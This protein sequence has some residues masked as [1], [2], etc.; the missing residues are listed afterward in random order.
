MTDKNSGPNRATAPSARTSG[1]PPRRWLW[2]LTLGLSLACFAVQLLFGTSEIDPHG[3]LY[4]PLF[5]LIP[6]SL[7]LLAI[8]VVLLALD[9][10]L[11]RSTRRDTAD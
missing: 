9:I 1:T 4:E 2:L 7:A 8:A 11:S 10:V 6:V 5:G 3:F